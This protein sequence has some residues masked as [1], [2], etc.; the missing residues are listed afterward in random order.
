MVT[1]FYRGA[2]GWSLLDSL[3]FS[4]VSL[5][6]IGFGDLTP[7]SPGAKAFT[8]AHSLLGI[9]VIAAFITTLASAG[10]RRPRAAGYRM[11]QPASAG[12]ASVRRGIHARTEAGRGPRLTDPTA[13]RGW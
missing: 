2:E 13:H 10:A 6:T 1:L 8:I 5:T 7:S 11:A 3:Y 9:G 4:V 12:S